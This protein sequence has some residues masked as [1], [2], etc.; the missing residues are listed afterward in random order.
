MKKETE[1]NYNSMRNPQFINNFHAWLIVMFCLFGNA[2]YEWNISKTNSSV[3][4]NVIII[5]I[6]IIMYIFH[7]LINALIAH[8]IHVNL[9]MIFYTHVEHNPAKTLAINSLVSSY[10][11]VSVYWAVQAGL[12]TPLTFARHRLSPLA[13]FTSGAYFLHNGRR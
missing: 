11:V 10:S 8:M 4:F 12:L 3:Q 7:A 2:L 5:T 13:A 1:I 6:M 9:N